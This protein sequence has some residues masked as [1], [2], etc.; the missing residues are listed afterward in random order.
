MTSRQKA[1]VPF[2]FTR[3]YEPRVILE[4]KFLMACHNSVT[5]TS[6]VV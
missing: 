3:S 1:L 5:G 4:R 2:F 6:G